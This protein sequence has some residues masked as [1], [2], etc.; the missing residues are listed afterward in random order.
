MELEVA[1][2]LFADTA[3]MLEPLIET[4]LVLGLLGHCHQH[5]AYGAGGDDAADNHYLAVG[6]AHNAVDDRT[7]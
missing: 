4:Y 5:P 1:I 2:Q 3:D 7:Q 6:T